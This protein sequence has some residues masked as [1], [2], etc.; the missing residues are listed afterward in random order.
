MPGV[1]RRA[2]VLGLLVSAVL[3]LSASPSLAAAEGATRPTLFAVGTTSVKFDNQGRS[4]ATT[5]YYPATGRATT[6]SIDGAPRATKW[7]PYPLIVFSHDL[8]ASPTPYARLL[9]AWAAAGYV[10]AV[11]TYEAPTDAEADEDGQ[12]V[13][14]LGER[15][16]D[17]S[18]V[19]DR[20][21]DRVQG[22]FGS[23]VD[24]QRIAAAG[25]GL[26]ATTTYV[27]SYL[28]TAPTHGCA[29]SS[30]SGARSPATPTSYFSG[31]NTPLLAIHGEAD[32]VDPI[33]DAHDVFALAK[34]PKFFVTLLG[35]DGTSPFATANDPAAAGRRGDHARLL[36]RVP[37]RP[38]ERARPT[39]ARRQDGRGLEDQ[40]RAA[41]ATSA[42]PG[43]DE[44]EAPCTRVSQPS[45][46]RLPT[47]SPTRP[48]SS[49][50]TAAVR[51]RELEDHA[52]RLAAGLSAEGIGA[53]AHVALFL[54]NCPEYMECLF[55]CSKLRALSANVNFRY[56]SGELAALLENA[57]A[58]V[59]VFHR[60]LGDRVAAV[61]DQL[62]KLRVLIEID[63]GG[64]A[65]A[66]PDA[67]AYD[68]LIAAHEPLPRI[69]RSGDD[70][71]LWYT[72]GTTGLPKG[73]LWH[74]GTL[75]N[76]GAVYAAGVID[77][78]VPESVSE[79]AE[80]A[81]EL[82]GRDIRPVPLLTT[83]LVHATAVHQANTWFSV[84][85]M[86]AL[87]PRG[88]VDGDVVCATIERERVTLLSLVGD[89]ILRRIVRALEG[90][91]ARRRALRPLVTPTRA[92]LGCDGERHAQGR[93]AQS[94]DDELLRLARLE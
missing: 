22:G 5:V 81:V 8:R 21:L 86:V 44:E 72:G 6:L 47:P 53:D 68:D 65:S 40:D 82:L 59:L 55:A 23:I 10:V 93:V 67:I 63:D 1:K 92:Q 73:V 16:T 51:W 52:A 19:I 35:A 32:E 60:S 20:M 61:R 3:A 77:R 14:D 54:F 38:V 85:G 36:H 45:G 12:F 66:V 83:P 50:A 4:V 57:D 69:E 90:A 79:A 29:P 78:P 41:L 64:A 58:E 7:G 13:V 74:Q 37:P 11:P 80:C 34:P 46:R 33:D 31:V 56:E 15:V 70:L 62:P 17:A 27:L 91:E 76:Y 75:L 18:F 9:H 84:G 88:R 25:H 39:R 42:T 94:G 30:P 26:G 89:V 87:L 43:S 48:P 71:L 49:R 28:A 24:R 2:A